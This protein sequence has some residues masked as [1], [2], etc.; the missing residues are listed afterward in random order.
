MDS[1]S[2]FQNPPQPPNSF[3]V[4]NDNLKS[5]A[6]VFS[7]IFRF[8][9]E[10]CIYLFGIRG[11]FMLA[12]LTEHKRFVMKQY[13]RSCGILPK[14]WEYT[15]T[16]IHDV[17]E[18]FELVLRKHDVPLQI[19]K[20]Y[21]NGLIHAIRFKLPVSVEKKQHTLTALLD[22]MK[23]DHDFINVMNVTIDKDDMSLYKGTV[24]I[25]NILYVLR[26]FWEN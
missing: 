7:F 19:E 9:K 5:A 13:M 3:S 6:D 8:Y 17:Y 16:D 18:R 4:H 1:I 15:D 25:N 21:N 12:N 26:F 14:I 10:G 23:N 22:I 20:I 11:N 24:R 2:I